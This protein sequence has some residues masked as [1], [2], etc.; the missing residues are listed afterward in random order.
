MLPKILSIVFLLVP[1]FAADSV[2][3]STLTVHEWGTFTSVAG[4]NGAPIPWASLAAPSDLPCFVYR[5]SAQCVK[6]AAR[7]TVRMETPV[8]YFY[9]SQP[10]TVDVHVDLPSGVI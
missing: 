5:L 1:A 10:Q 3:P 2:P 6:C 4:E 7:S 9:A 8:I